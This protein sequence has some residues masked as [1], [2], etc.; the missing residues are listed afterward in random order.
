VDP[1]TAEQEALVACLARRSEKLARIYDS[2]LRVFNDDENPGRFPLAAH[3]MR[4]LLEK[5]S[6]LTEGEELPTGDGMK[7]RIEPVKQAFLAATRAQ[8]FSE[9]FPLDAIEGAVRALLGELGRFFKWLEDNRPQAVK[10]TAETLAKLS[11]PGQA[12]PVDI[13]DNEVAGWMEAH[14]YFN[15]VAHNRQDNVNQ[16]EFKHHMTFIEGILLH[17]LQ[18]TAVADHD[19]LDALVGEGEHDH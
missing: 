11:G 8:G 19:A 7:N 3:S 17:R 10:R 5:I 18:P 4:E 1:P 15:M 9:I 14:S 6:V 2:G 12:L 16:D 13:F